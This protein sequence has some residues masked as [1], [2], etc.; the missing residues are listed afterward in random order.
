MLFRSGVGL[1]LGSS[2]SYG[3]PY[4]RYFNIDLFQRSGSLIPSKPP[5]KS[6]TPISGSKIPVSWNGY[7]DPKDGSGP[8]LGVFLSHCTNNKSPRTAQYWNYPA[9][10]FFSLL[11]P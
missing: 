9:N 4:S 7:D 11:K 8:G 5:G 10:T 2:A 3:A 6:T 1:T